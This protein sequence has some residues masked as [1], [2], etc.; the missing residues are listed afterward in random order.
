MSEFASKGK[1]SH[2][3]HDVGDFTA[4]AYEKILQLNEKK[5]KQLRTGFNLNPVEIDHI[6]TSNTVDVD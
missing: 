2:I 1:A 6:V 5:S 3:Q 4:Q